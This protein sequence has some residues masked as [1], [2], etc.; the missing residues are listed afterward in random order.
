MSSVYSCEACIHVLASPDRDLLNGWKLAL[1]SIQQSVIMI[2]A[3]CCA[4]GLIESSLAEFICIQLSMIQVN[5]VL[6]RMTELSNS[7]VSVRP[8]LHF[9]NRSGIS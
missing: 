2:I 4:S 8:C 9:Q 1:Q 6:F 5:K 7:I 3:A